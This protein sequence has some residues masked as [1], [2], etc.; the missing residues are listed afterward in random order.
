M[1]ESCHTTEYRII[2]HPTSSKNF[3]PETKY[4]EI[5][6]L[7]INSWGCW[8]H[9][10]LI[11]D[12]N[13]DVF[14]PRWDNSLGLQ[15]S[16]WPV[17]STCAQKSLIGKTGLD[18][19]VG[20]ESKQNKY[21]SNVRWIFDKKDKITVIYDWFIKYFHQTRMHFKLFDHLPNLSSEGIIW[22]QTTVILNNWFIFALKNTYLSCISNNLDIYFII[23]SIIQFFSV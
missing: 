17:D 1:C 14:G 13:P 11:F 12:I 10:Y 5:F 9:F 23:F 7:R 15:N 6:N 3:F 4:L 20:N 21:I 2:A 22:K 19:N 16:H 8:A 18:W